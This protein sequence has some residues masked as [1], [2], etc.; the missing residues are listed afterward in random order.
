MKKLHSYVKIAIVSNVFMIFLQTG[1]LSQ[2]IIRESINSFGGTGHINNIRI[3]E[4]VG[5]AFNTQTSGNVSLVFHP[6]FQQQMTLIKEEIVME[7][8][9]INVQIYPNPAS[10]ELWITSSE[11][12]K[13]AIISIIDMNGKVIEEKSLK[14]F[15]ETNFD[16]SGWMDGIYAIK[17]LNNKQQQAKSSIIFVIK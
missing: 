12:M 8:E 13:E 9:D 10:S 1:L 17:L 16:V 15:R 14:N 6:G 3:S 5:Q 7:L 2:A 11:K 4:T